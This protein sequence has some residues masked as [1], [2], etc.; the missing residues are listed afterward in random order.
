MYFLHV[1]AKTCRRCT[2]CIKYIKLTGRKKKNTKIFL[3]IFF[4]PKTIPV[5]SNFQDQLYNVLIIT[6]VAVFSIKQ[7]NPIFATIPTPR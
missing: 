5:E 2:V 6:V 4:L 7:R 1:V 3:K